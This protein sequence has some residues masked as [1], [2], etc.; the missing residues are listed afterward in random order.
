MTSPQGPS[1][2]PAGWYP[3]P[4]GSGQQRY[5]DG[6]QWT[7]HHSGGAPGQ[8][9]GAPAYVQP[10]ST[11]AAKRPPGLWWGMPP[12]VLLAIIGSLG[13]WVTVEAGG[14][15]ESAGGLE[16]DGWITLIL[17]L[18]AGGLLVLWLAQRRAWQAIVAAVAAGI[19]TAV[20][21]YHVIAPSA[22]EESLGGLIEASAGSGVWLAF[23]ALLALTVLSI[24]L[25]V[26]SG[27]GAGA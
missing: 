24:V 4:S 20:A 14:F 7:D 8:A 21:F 9:A 23:I 19:A 11:A 25:A 26:R 6:A 17:A 10:P 12:A 3:D 15:S 18:V 22:G 27:R 2:T 16:G 1:Q 5:W 13:P